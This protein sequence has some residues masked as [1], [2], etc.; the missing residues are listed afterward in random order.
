MLE[1][2]HVYLST[3]AL[4]ISSSNM[5]VMTITFEKSC[6]PVIELGQE[7]ILFITQTLPRLGERFVFTLMLK[8]RLKFNFLNK[9]IF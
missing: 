3:L 7:I 9:I 2:I 1:N 6:Y 8:H 4:D 5:N